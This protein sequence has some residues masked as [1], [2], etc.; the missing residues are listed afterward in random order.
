LTCDQAITH[1]LHAVDDPRALDASAR[2]ALA[3]HLAACTRC[4]R[5]FEDQRAVAALLRGRPPDLPSPEFLAA[6]ASRLDA[7]GG[8]LAIADWR[9][10]T[11]R[12]A[13]IAAVLVLGALFTT[14]TPPSSPVSRPNWESADPTSAASVLWQLDMPPDSVVET[15]I[16]GRAPAGS[17]R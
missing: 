6:L 1:L 2:V 10:W 4:Q 12:L 11:L 15:L 8:W 13:P 5:D 7:A 14:G 16:T 9:R 3:A 17:R